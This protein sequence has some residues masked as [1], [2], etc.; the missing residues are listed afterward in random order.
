MEYRQNEKYKS[1]LAETKKGRWVTINKT[2]IFIKKGQ[3]IDQAIEDLR[4]LQEA[5]KNK[6]R[7]NDEKNIQSRV[8]QARQEYREIIRKNGRMNTTFYTWHYIYRLEITE[9]GYRILWKKENK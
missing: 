5:K 8:M 2:P 4:K 9:T 7:S 3:T 1:I 6:E